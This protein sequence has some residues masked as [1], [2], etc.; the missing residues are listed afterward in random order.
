VFLL[1]YCNYLQAEFESAPFPSGNIIPKYHQFTAPFKFN[2]AINE[3]E[4][5][6][7]SVWFSVTGE[8]TL[9]YGIFFISFNFFKKKGKKQQV[10]YTL[11]CSC[12]NH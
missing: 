8:V 7:T 10:R 12:S 11:R 2:K 3:E 9:A 1:D 6:L 4:Q 5:R